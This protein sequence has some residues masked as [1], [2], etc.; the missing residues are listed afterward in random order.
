VA[1]IAPK[2][3]AAAQPQVIKDVQ[4]PWV[5]R[6][7]IVKGRTLMTA[8]TGK[9]VQ[10]RVSCDRLDLAAPNGRITAAGNVHVS[11]EGLEGSCEQLTI[12]WAEDRVT[13]EGQAELRTKRDGQDMDMKAAKLSLRL[14]VARG[15][16]PRGKRD[17]LERTTGVEMEGRT[18]P[19]LIRSEPRPPVITESRDPGPAKE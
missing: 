18:A 12:A 11:S 7:E 2:P 10:F 19:T 1:P 16:E 13:L 6:V 9:E 5:L 17:L 15:E 3:A 4:C 14:S 8:S